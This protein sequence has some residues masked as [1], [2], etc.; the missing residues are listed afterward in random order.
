[1]LL[2]LLQPSNPFYCVDHN[3]MH[4][5]G[6]C[7]C[8]SSDCVNKTGR[9]KHISSIIYKYHMCNKINQF[10]VVHSATNK[11]NRYDIF[12]I[13]LKVALNTINQPTNQ[14]IFPSYVVFGV[15]CPMCHVSLFCSFLI[16]LRFSPTFMY[17][18]DFYEIQAPLT[19]LLVS[20]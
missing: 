19:M 9:Y 4:R 13:L 8:N 14:I 20:E 17:I 11:A 3:S 7:Y 12:E 18:C 15:L 1:M 6:G 2:N 10:Q 16:S 5:H